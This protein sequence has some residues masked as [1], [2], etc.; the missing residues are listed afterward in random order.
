MQ[1]RS[2]AQPV[3]LPSFI[4]CKMKRKLLSLMLLVLSAVKMKDSKTDRHKRAFWDLLQP[5][6]AASPSKFATWQWWSACLIQWCVSPYNVHAEMHPQTQL[7]VC[8]KTGRLSDNIIS[9]SLSVCITFFSLS[10]SL[11]P[12]PCLSLCLS[13]GNRW[14]TILRDHSLCYVSG[15]HQCVG[16]EISTARV[17]ACRPD[18]QK[19]RMGWD[20]GLLPW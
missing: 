20:Y 5:Q 14:R 13:R 16:V 15:A 11:S 4:P 6:E 10:L 19:F 18:A 8:S 3:C 9:V 1:S 7:G 12:P 17:W 2:G